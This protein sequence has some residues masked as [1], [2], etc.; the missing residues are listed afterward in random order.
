MDLSIIGAGGHGRELASIARAQFGSNCRI[1]FW[2]DKLEAGDHD[3]GVVAGS[4]ADL[5]AVG[6]ETFAVGVGDPT[7]RAE[8]VERLDAAGGI[9]QTLIHPAAS[10]GTHCDIA[11]GAVIGA[12]SV[13]TTGIRVG[14]HA[15]IHSQV[16]VA[17]DCQIGNFS[18]LTPSVALAGDV[19]IGSHAWIGI[20]ASVN[21]GLT[22]GSH[23]V[24]GAGAVVLSDVS[25][26]ATVVGIPARPIENRW[27]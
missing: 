16:V 8:L 13:L 12:N 20:G 4:L 7:V 24:V 9:A 23:A 14:L 25:I 5:L 1:R 22:I 15:H 21:R 10:V 17:H 2:D 18:L 11:A 19:V 3:F 27:S 26:G 6:V